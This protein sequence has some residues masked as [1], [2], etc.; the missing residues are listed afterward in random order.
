MRLVALVKS[1]ARS[2]RDAVAGDREVRALVE[3]H[4]RLA[5]FVRSRLRRGQFS[6]LPLT[7]LGVLFIYLAFLLLGTIE[8]IVTTDPLVAVD[9]RIDHLLASFRNPWLTRL[10]L[11]VTALGFW[12]V[13]LS[14]AITLS[15]YLLLKRR[16]FALACFW[17]SLAGGTLVTFLGKFTFHRSR[18]LDAV[19]LERSWSYPSGHSST[20]IIL[21]GLAV[22]LLWGE[23]KASRIRWLILL[24]GAALAGGIGFSR[25]YLG[26]H[27]LSDV[28]SGFLLGFLVLISGITVMEWFERGSKGLV[29][30]SPGLPRGRVA[31]LSLLVAVEVLFAGSWVWRFHPPLLP[32]PAHAAGIAA[33][34][35]LFSEDRLPRRTETLM[36]NDQEP[37]SFILSARGEAGLI[38]AMAGAGWMA[39]ERPRLRGLFHLARAAL[40]DKAYPS[41]P[42]TPS[43]WNGWPHDLGFEKPVPGK[44]VRERHHAR[45][46]RTGY[47]TPRGMDIYVGTASLDVGIKWGVIHRIRPD[48][49]SERDILAA[50]LQRA[51]MIDGARKVPLVDPVMGTNFSGDP[52][53]TD[54][55]AVI[56]G[57]T[58]SASER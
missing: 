51:G 25:L 15:V 28:W 44:G 5:A 6:G 1:L 33:G 37:L 7:L 9:L 14:V 18:P 39:A 30:P 23:V 50:D 24:A 45:F 35:D 42:M 46:W 58:E 49:D 48:I 41:A 20:A 55:Q 52:F 36:G 13:V 4:P 32:P 43:F 3:R 29:S 56:A 17:L 22:Y 21:W 54:G 19:Y 12:P 47:R 8:D 34:L 11:M 40:G 16:G 31:L 38:A 2:V 53:F 26:V 57:I 27:Y 10:F